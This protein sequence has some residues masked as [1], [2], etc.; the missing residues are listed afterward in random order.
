LIDDRVDDDRD[1]DAGGAKAGGANFAD[2]EQFFLGAFRIE[3]GQVEVAHKDATAWLRLASRFVTVEA[4]MPQM[5]SP[6]IPCGSTSARSSERRRAPDGEP[7]GESDGHVRMGGE[8]EA[9]MGN[10]PDERSDQGAEEGMINILPRMAVAAAMRYL[11][12]L[13][14]RHVKRLLSVRPRKKKRKNCDRAISFQWNR[15]G[16]PSRSAPTRR[17]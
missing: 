5:S 15:G 13:S 16:E 2:D 6:S 14:M 10:E 17:Q 11:A 1:G 3:N 12:E 8:M 7:G 9:A 4:K